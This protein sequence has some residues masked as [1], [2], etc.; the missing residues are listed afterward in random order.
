[1]SPDFSTAR[2]FDQPFPS[3][4]AEGVIEPVLASAALEW[5]ERDAPWRLRQTDFYEQHEFSLLD[6]S[7]PDSLSAL[8]SA[9]FVACVGKGLGDALGA[10]ALALVEVAAHRLTAGQTIRLHN[11]YLEN[12]EETH[13]LL[14]QLTR[15]WQANFGGYLM[16]FES[17]QPESVTELL[18]PVHRGAFGFEI[19]PRSFH[20]VSTINAGQR[21]TLVYTFRRT[22]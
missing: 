1:M 11:D 3:W 21:H 7:L 22:Q 10:S 13:R 9:Q 20:A 8:A 18:L 14:I 16:L 12:G 19:S 5:L 2:R 4:R 6:A 17:D 15:G